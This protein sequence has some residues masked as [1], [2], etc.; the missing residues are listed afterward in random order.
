MHLGLT[1]TIRIAHLK[2]PTLTISAKTFSPL[3][4]VALQVPGVRMWISLGT[5]CGEAEGVM[6]RHVPEEAIT[7]EVEVG[8]GRIQ[9][10]CACVHLNECSSAP[11]HMDLVT[12]Q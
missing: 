11:G 4:K 7:L 8:R 5:E 1:Q 2:I 3:Y 12:L 10:L 6:L 9:H